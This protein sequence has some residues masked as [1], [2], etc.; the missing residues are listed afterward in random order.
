MADGLYCLTGNQV[1]K[2]GDIIMSP[3]PRTTQ[4]IIS[5]GGLARLL[6]TMT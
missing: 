3:Y 5:S 2:P 4:R 6:L 1:P